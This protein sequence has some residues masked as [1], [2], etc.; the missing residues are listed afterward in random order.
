MID[1]GKPMSENNNNQSSLADTTELM[2]LA[3]QKFSDGDYGKCLEIYTGL[4]QDSTN[5]NYYEILLNRA[6]LH[7]TMKNNV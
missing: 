4:L 5:P 7:L 6:S 3:S 1:E 2:K